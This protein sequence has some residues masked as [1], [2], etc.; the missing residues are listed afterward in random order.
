MPGVILWPLC[1]LVFSDP[2]L[3]WFGILLKIGEIVIIISNICSTSFSS[4]SSVPVMHMQELICPLVLRNSAWVCLF[5]FNCS[6]LC[7]S[8]L[9]VSIDKA[10]SSVILF[11][12][13]QVYCLTHQSHSSLLYC[14]LFVTFLSD[15]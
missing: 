12:H 4:P 10:S 13:V 2:P 3:L 1:C 11:S 6:S 14:F 8:F 15:S 7:F 5:F 9:E